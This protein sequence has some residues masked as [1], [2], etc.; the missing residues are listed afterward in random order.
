[1]AVEGKSLVASQAHM[2]VDSWT[3]VHILAALSGL[4]GFK[5][6]KHESGKSKGR[7]GEWEGWGGLD[8]DA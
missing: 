8:Q 1:M 5:E 7:W 6:R 2:P 3:S 4:S